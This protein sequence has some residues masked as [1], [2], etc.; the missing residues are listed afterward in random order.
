MGTCES[1][2]KQLKQ[3]FMKV[4]PPKKMDS[5]YQFINTPTS[6]IS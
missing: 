2:V 4:K 1:N 6:S 5:T 3:E